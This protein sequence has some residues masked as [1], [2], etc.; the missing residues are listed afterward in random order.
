MKKIITFVWATFMM[1]SCMEGDPLHDI[2]GEHIKS[3]VERDTLYAVADTSIVEGKVSTANGTKLLL[4]SHADFETR[5]LIRFSGLPADTIQI[6]SLRLMFTSVS[7]LGEAVGSIGGTAYLVTEDWPASVNEDE[8]WDYRTKID[9]TPELTANFEIN[10]ETETYHLIELPPAMIDVWRDTT[11]GNNN[12]GLLLDYSSADYI[13]QFL[14]AE[15]TFSGQRPRLIA[16]YHDA[17]L[18][19]IVHDTLFVD[20]DASL[21]D[22]N[23]TYDPS[24]VQ[25]ASGYTVRSFFYFDLS[26]LPET[27]A[28]ATMHFILN[29]D[30]VNSIVNE[31]T[32]EEM[33]FRTITTPYEELP[34]YKVDSTFTQNIYYSVTLEETSVKHTL[35][36]RSLER[37]YAS[38]N[39][40]QD[41]LNGDIIYGSFMAQYKMEGNDIS[42]YTVRDNADPDMISRPKLIVEYYV[43]PNTRL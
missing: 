32:K 3:G 31:N 40:L 17:A 29:R 36:I 38:Q 34:Y 26:V 42:V 41:I 8:S 23:G 43:I 14:S 6:D 37:G 33:S 9:Y 20:K 24:K 22:F 5:F 39:F 19:T 30:T 2:S 15:A 4:G 11:G 21:I 10:S 1:W 12:H 27:A 35:D 13:K 18:D 28:M 7:N 25:I 16:V